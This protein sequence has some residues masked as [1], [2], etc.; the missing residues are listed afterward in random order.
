MRLFKMIK[1]AAHAMN[2]ITVLP[3]PEYELVILPGC[4]APVLKQ[5]RPGYFPTRKPMCVS[6]GS[7]LNMR[8]PSSVVEMA[9]MQK[10]WAVIRTNAFPREVMLDYWP[11]VDKP[12]LVMLE[13]LPGIVE[14]VMVPFNYT[15]NEGMDHHELA[16]LEY[17]RDNDVVPERMMVVGEI[18]LGE[19]QSIKVVQFAIHTANSIIAWNYVGI[20]GEII[21]PPR[22]GGAVHLFADCEFEDS[23][24]SLIS[25]GLVNENG[26]VYYAFDSNAANDVKEE[27]VQE[28]V[29]NV[30]MNVPS[31]TIVWD[32]VAKKQTFQDFM[33]FVIGQECSKGASETVIHTD[34]PTD[35][36]YIS[37]LFHLGMGNRI[38]TMHRLSFV[39]DYVDPYPSK[40]EHAV[41]HNAAW[42]AMVLWFHLGYP[43]RKMVR[44]VLAGSGNTS[45]K[46]APKDPDR[47]GPP[48]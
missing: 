21:Q 20:D 25:L 16:F 47:I 2:R 38:G 22:T 24:K 23:R 30:L 43:H 41:Q 14:G 48:W 1:D 45:N 42:D 11:P 8:P 35:V 6:Y 26:K 33:Q 36:A 4:H 15:D 5:N 19:M 40:L 17:I 32:L 7:Y 27:W 34:F 18:N 29:N 46:S 3:N 31:S 13:G 10:D 39:V 44:S 9:E 28:N 37:P 12:L